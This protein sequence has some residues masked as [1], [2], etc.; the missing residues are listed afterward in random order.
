[1]ALAARHVRLWRSV[2]GGREAVHLCADCS[3]EAHAALREGARHAY[4]QPQVCRPSLT[5]V[6]LE[7]T[8]SKENSCGYLS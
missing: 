5:S 8:A 4:R 2:L 3:M 7:C 6:P 1:M